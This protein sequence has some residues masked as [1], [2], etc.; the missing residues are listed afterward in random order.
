MIFFCYLYYTLRLERGR[1]PTSPCPRSSPPRRA[2]FLPAIPPLPTP[3]SFLQSRPHPRRLPSSH[4]TCRTRASHHRR[5]SRPQPTHPPTP[6]PPRSRIRSVYGRPPRAMP[7]HPRIPPPPP[8]PR[9]HAASNGFRAPV[10]RDLTSAPSMEGHHASCILGLRAPSSDTMPSHPASGCLC[11]HYPQPPPRAI[12]APPSSP[13]TP[14][15]SVFSTPACIVIPSGTA[16]PVPLAYPPARQPPSST[17]L[18]P[19]AMTPSI[20]GSSRPTARRSTPTTEDSSMTTF[21]IG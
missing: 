13:E 2:V 9:P 18:T 10:P 14:R 11:R 17:C 12:N 15:P 20:P 16:A 19:L 1:P 8:P 7:S 4:P 3:S 6:V 5:E 21:S